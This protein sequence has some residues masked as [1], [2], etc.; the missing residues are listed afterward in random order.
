MILLSILFF[1]LNC[2]N[3]IYR[4]RLCKFTYNNS[5]LRINNYTKIKNCFIFHNNNTLDICFRGTSNINDICYNL[6]I[7]PKSFIKDE[8]KVHSG[9]LNKYLVI[10]DMIINKT[11]EIMNNN[12]IEHIYLSGHS[13]GG[14]IANIAS[15]DYHYLYPNITINT[16][17]F[18]SPRVANKAFIEEYNKKIKNSVRIVNDNDIIQFLPL[19]IIYHHIH[20]PLVLHNNNKDV[21][22]IKFIMDSHGTNSYIKNLKKISY[23]D[24]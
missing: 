1:M 5:Y 9:F 10:R 20:E 24:I 6:N 17:T 21:N 15:L 11:K 7:I 3:L 19:P 8:F 13:S 12:Q 18:G 16:I 23:I 14:A 22:I 4:A 2:N